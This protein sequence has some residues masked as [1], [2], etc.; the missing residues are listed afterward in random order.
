MVIILVALLCMCITCNLTFLAE[1]GIDNANNN[2]GGNDD[3]DNDGEDIEEEDKDHQMA[4]ASMPLPLLL[5]MLRKCPAPL[6]NAPLRSMLHKWWLQLPML[7]S[8]QPMLL[9][10]I[11]TCS[12]LT[13]KQGALTSS[14][15]LPL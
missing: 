14:P 15:Q 1:E 10:L 6:Q 9:M 11:Q 13:L 8:L 3:N 4:P 5:V 12:A 7:T 2:E